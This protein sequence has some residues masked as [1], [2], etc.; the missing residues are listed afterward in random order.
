MIQKKILI[1]INRYFILTTIVFFCGYFTIECSEQCKPNSIIQNTLRP[2]SVALQEVFVFE[3]IKSITTKFIEELRYSDLKPNYHQSINNIKFLANLTVVNKDFNEKIKNTLT[4]KLKSY[5]YSSYGFLMKEKIYENIHAD[6]YKKYEE[7][8]GDYYEISRSYSK[9]PWRFFNNKGY[10][11]DVFY[12]IN[13]YLPPLIILCM[14]NPPEKKNILEQ[15]KKSFYID[16]QFFTWA[17]VEKAEII[18]QELEYNKEIPS[19]EIFIHN[20]KLENKNKGALFMFNVLNNGNIRIQNSTSSNGVCFNIYSS[21]PEA[22]K[23]I[24]Q[25]SLKNI[26]ATSAFFTI[27]FENPPYNN[28]KNIIKNCHITFDNDSSVDTIVFENCHANN[29]VIEEAVNNKSGNFTIHMP[30]ENTINNIRLIKNKQNTKTGAIYFDKNACSKNRQKRMRDNKELKRKIESFDLTLTEGPLVET[31]TYLDEKTLERLSIDIK[32]YNGAYDEYD[33]RKFNNL[34]EFI[35]NY[36]KKEGGFEK[37][38]NLQIRTP[39]NLKKLEIHSME[40]P[41][42]KNCMTVWTINNQKSPLDLESLVL[43]NQNIKINFAGKIFHKIN[44]LTCGVNQD[45]LNYL[46]KHVIELKTANFICDEQLDKPKD[47]DLYYSC[48]YKDEYHNPVWDFSSFASLKDL[49]V[50]LKDIHSKIIVPE[51][52]KKFKIIPAKFEAIKIEKNCIKT[53]HVTPADSYDPI[54]P[55]SI[56][57]FIDNNLNK[58][59]IKEIYLNFASRKFEPNDPITIDLQGF[60]VL[61]KFEIDTAQKVVDFKNIPS[62]CKV[63][64]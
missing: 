34:K 38:S 61:E 2:N 30:E 58:E 3:C 54:L 41:G 37:N 26:K 39:N 63:Y 18:K 33:L 32:N 29:L 40:Q 35:L 48:K 23:T 17:R 36:S 50:Q 60:N 10:D 59:T 24:E 28:Q 4:N 56:Q 55:D 51:S 16:D 14:I 47:K 43:D 52:V 45:I 7:I 19:K 20:A 53:I 11:D 15:P 5:I 31:L 9:G 8:I 27:K 57:E 22:I 21:N 44:H 49:T 25:L 42:L 12:A 46:A 62:H 1:K 13:T 64:L 6:I